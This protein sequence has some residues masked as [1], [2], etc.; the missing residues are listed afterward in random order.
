MEVRDRVFLAN[1]AFIPVIRDLFPAFGP[2]EVAGG[3][4]DGEEGLED[5]LVEDTLCLLVDVLWRGGGQV[6]YFRVLGRFADHEAVDEGIGGGLHGYTG[7][8]TVEEVGV[9]IDA[10]AE[11]VRPEVNKDI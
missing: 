6:A 9:I 1:G 11:P 4:G 10:L 8:W 3:T 7:E 2:D 5:V